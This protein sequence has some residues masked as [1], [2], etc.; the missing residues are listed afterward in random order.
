MNSVQ[1]EYQPHII[2]Q[3]Q[4]AE[5]QFLSAY[6]Q[7]NYTPEA[8][9]VIL[10]P[11][12]NA[13]L[14]ALILFHTDEPISVT[15]S[16]L[17]KT[18]EA[19][20]HHTFEAATEHVLP[21]YGLYPAMDN[22]VTLTLDNKTVSKISITTESAP[23]C[24]MEPEYIK[25]TASYMQE[26]M[27]FL[28]PSSASKMVARDFAG[29]L[30]WYCS[31]DTVM[32]PKR[33]DN[34]HLMVATERL[35]QS[36]Y[37]VTG[38][39]EMDLLGKIYKEYR[40][41]G[42][43]HHDFTRDKDGNLILLSEDFNRNTVEDMCVV[44]DPTTGNIIRS[45]DMAALLPKTAAAGNRVTE[46]DWMHC[47]AVWYDAN[48]NS[49]SISGRNLD[50]IVNID[51]STG[52]LNWILGDPAKWPQDYVERYFFTP[53]ESDEEFEW[54]HAQ[55][56]CVMLPDGDMLVFDNGAWRSKYA[57]QDI[58]AE[59]KYSRAVRYHLNM[60]EKTVS[61]V[62]QYGKER[63][64]EFFSPH[65]SNVD[66]Y[67]PDHYLVHS[68]DVGQISGK[69]CE[70]PPIFFLNRPEAKDLVYYS[71]TTMILNDEVVFEMKIPSTAY[72]RA[73]RMPLYLEK[74]NFSFGFGNQLG[75]LGNTPT[76]RLRTPKKIQEIPDNMVVRILDEMD[77]LRVSAM[78]EVGTYAC[79][80]LQQNEEQHCYLIPTTEK[81]ELAMCITTL[82]AANHGE[83][84][85]ALSKEGLKGS[86]DLYL[87][88]EQN[89]YTLHKSI[90]C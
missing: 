87:L 40:V 75:T 37:Y 56:A 17:G 50:A 24:I 21:I 54:F 43:L 84:V 11:Y 61:Q 62:W 35:I 51:Y 53:E 89:Y 5:Q 45:F 47:N 26:D 23:E 33:L 39:Y 60:K 66:Y 25:T 71:I 57:E 68:G 83:S 49:I 29:D 85:V 72:F 36:P 77:R 18:P 74:E 20:V 16:V 76:V 46:H 73:K 4:K 44:V 34:G 7:G 13:P 42:G 52:S 32:E 70:K 15:V 1:Y 63:G 55:H 3:Q 58:P 65:I 8:P 38:V 79:L 86:Y 67:G 19:N 9:Y 14:T 2:Q 28:T 78:L 69:P 81:D 90:S 64:S 12:G 31:L 6:Q 80:V 41:P 27:M 82:T 22:T 59:E 30:R 88:I 48:S 10:N